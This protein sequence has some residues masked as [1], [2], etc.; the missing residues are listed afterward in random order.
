MKMTENLTYD[1]YNYFE[2]SLNC[3][4]I[5]CK[6][7]GL[8]I[9][10]RNDIMYRTG[11]VLAKG[12]G[13]LNMAENLGIR[14][15][16]TIQSAMERWLYRYKKDSVKT[17]TF[18]RLLTSYKLLGKYPLSNIRLMDLCT[19]DIQGMVNTL[20]CEGYSMS[21]IKK[22]YNLMTGFLTFALGEGLAIR[23]AHLNVVL[24]RSEN[25]TKQAREVKAYEPDEQTRLKSVVEKFDTPGAHAALLMIETGMRVGEVL[26][27]TW[28]DVW[29][30]RRALRIHATMVNPQSRQHSFVQNSPKSRSSVRTIPLSKAALELLTR[31]K[32]PEGGLIF[33]ADD[34]KTTIGY[35]SLRNQ[36]QDLCQAAEVP[37]YGMHAFRHT[38]ATNAFYKGCEIKRLSKMLGHANVTITYNTY[39]HLYGDALEEMR[40]IVE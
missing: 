25:L 1:T 30:Q 7:S 12:Q 8:I 37:Y 40:S 3:T 14:A 31:L 26:A 17:A 21:T 39:I 38:F 29:W 24:P 19:D 36:I 4:C 9:I 27:L 22:A 32:K 16:D 15:T 11:A 2:C 35:N 20:R 13:G 34:G 5:V 18:N 10:K 33:V 28:S 6:E 23:P